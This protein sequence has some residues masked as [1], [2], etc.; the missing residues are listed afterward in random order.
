MASNLPASPGSTVAA[1]CRDSLLG[2]LWSLIGARS[3]AYV[4]AG[5]PA[6]GPG[7]CGWGSTT[8]TYQVAPVEPAPTEG[9]GETGALGSGDGASVPAQIAIVIRRE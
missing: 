7:W 4:G 3:P 6:S 1:P 8:P 5:Q 2:W 9:D